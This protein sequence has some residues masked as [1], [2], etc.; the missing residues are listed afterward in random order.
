MT[1]EQERIRACLEAQ[2][3][4]FCDQTGFSQ[5]ATHVSMKHGI[6]RWALKDMAG[7][8]AHD[9]IVTDETR[10]KRRQL[11]A[12]QGFGTAVRPTPQKH[13]VDPEKPTRRQAKFN[14]MTDE[15]RKAWAA[16]RHQARETKRAN[17]R[18]K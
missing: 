12:Q 8:L 18:T 7:M 15:E 1:D 10:Q 16:K 14:A 4:P 2:Q 11:A 13:T 5:V 3:C 6:D 17:G 9:T